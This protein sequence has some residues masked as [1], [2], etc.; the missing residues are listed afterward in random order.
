MF[1]V[2]KLLKVREW[3]FALLAV[4]LIVLQVWLDLTM[5]DYMATI[6]QLAVTGSSANMGELWKNGAFM[7]ACA[8]GSALSA[9]AVG[10]FVA[11][12]AAAVSFR[13]RAQVFDK[14]ES[15]SM[16]EINRFSTASLITR[17]TNDIMQ[18]QMVMSSFYI[19]F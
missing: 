15:F 5:P 19:L 17:T 1:R 11:R 8:L 3:I 2:L 10:F 13:L 4:G 12:I 7:L 14:V 16:E 6:T 9:V 18:V